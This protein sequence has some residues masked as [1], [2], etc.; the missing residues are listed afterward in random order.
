ML[1][2]MMNSINDMSKALNSL[3]FEVAKLRLKLEEYENEVREL[4]KRLEDINKSKTIKR[5]WFK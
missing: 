1:D 2:N 5:R 3:A 4:R